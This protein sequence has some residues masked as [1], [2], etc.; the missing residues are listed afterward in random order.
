MFKAID[1]NLFVDW[2]LG[3][4]HHIIFPRYSN[5][6]VCRHIGYAGHSNR[7]KDVEQTN[8]ELNVDH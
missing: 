1:H 3:S 5:N 4:A 7:R 2:R 6:S 8:H